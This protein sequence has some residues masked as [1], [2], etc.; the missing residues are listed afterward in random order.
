M[1]Y[2]PPPGDAVMLEFSRSPTT[3]ITRAGKGS[4]LTWNEADGNFLN[5]KDT[6]DAAVPFANLGS[7]IAAWL[8]TPTSANL[9]AAL[10]D[11]TGTGAAVFA[12]MPTLSAPILASVALLPTPAV[13]AVEFLTDKLYATITTG[14]ARKEIALCD[15]SLTDGVVPHAAPGMNGRLMD[16][17]I[18]FDM[19]NRRVAVFDA[20]AAPVDFSIV[21]II[22]G[23][24]QVRIL[25]N[26]ATGTATQSVLAVGMALNP[27]QALQFRKYGPAAAWT[28]PGSDLRSTDAGHISLPV[29]NL[30]LTATAGATVFS[31]GGT[32]NSNEVARMT[33]AGVSISGGATPITSPS[34]RLHLGAGSAAAGTAPF[35][36][37]SGVLLTTA[38]PGAVEYLTDSFYATIATGS[39]RKEIALCDQT[40]TAGRLPI[41]GT[42]G[43][44]TDSVAWQ[45]INT[46]TRLQLLQTVNGDVSYVVQNQSTGIAAYA[47]LFAVNN[48][49]NFFGLYKLG[50]GYATAGLLAAG[51]NVLSSDS[52]DFLLAT[53]TS[54]ARFV[55]AAGGTA[56]AN[57]IARVQA[58]G[59]AIGTNLAPTARLHIAAGSATAGTAPIKLTAGPLNSIPEPGALEYDGSNVYFSL[60]GTRLVLTLLAGVNV[61]SPTSPNRTIPITIGGT[62][63]YLAA[64]T[65][66]D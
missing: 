28:P 10:T 42:N 44:L 30:L 23:S 47:G 61:V 59:I 19:V 50:T 21:K 35:K 32:A 39:A 56:T 60:P 45:F 17:E 65:T 37:T 1:T 9:A 46:N 55:F 33:A 38:E 51:A 27:G 54:A 58:P 62:T 22:D 43:R 16:S 18:R 6:A 66:N 52:A 63:Y 14:A 15:S 2:I 57:E 29:G 49:A 20:P 5:L 31:N 40:L 34:A 25:N 13:G 7:G 48:S 41:V 64:K 53:S 12:N 26:N 3:I 24:L 11:E 36:L 8:S 4:E